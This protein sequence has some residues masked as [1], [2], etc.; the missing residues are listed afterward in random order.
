MSSQISAIDTL[1]VLFCAG[2]VLLMCPALGLFYGGMVSRKNV[3]NTAFAAFAA[4]APIFVQWVAFGYSIAFGSDFF[5]LFGG[6]DKIFLQNAA[7]SHIGGISE[8]LFAFFQAAFAVIGAAII[9]GAFAERMRF[10]VLLLFIVLWSAFVYDILAHWVWG[11]GWLMKIGSLDFAGGGVVH[12][13]AGVAGLVGALFLGRRKFARGLLPHSLPLSFIGAVLLWLGWLGFNA[14][15]ALSVNSIAVN[16]FIVSN[17]SVAAAVLSWIFLEWLKFGKPT[18]L[19]ALSGV[20]AGLVAATPGAG[21]IEPFA[22]LFVG[23]LASPICF[24]AISSLKN[25]FGYDDTLDA[26]GLHGV[27]GIWG[28]LCVGLFASFDVNAI[29]ASEAA[30]AGLF[31][32]GGFALLGVQIVAVLACAAFSGIVSYLILKIISY[33]TPLR[34]EEFEEVNGLDSSLHGELAYR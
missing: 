6:L 11:G 5:G 12:I 31:Y 10:G 8:L 25:K 9:T 26:F 21:F 24:F 28:G 29:V 15:S 3:L 32:G 17:L 30:S 20:V 23:F 18:L 22:A 4:F 19:G 1:F 13:A 33:F 34:V 27:G 7:N 2:G 14:G 16:A